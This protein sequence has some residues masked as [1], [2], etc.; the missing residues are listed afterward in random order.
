MPAHLGLGGFLVSSRLPNLTPG[1]FHLF[2]PLLIFSPHHIQIS[3]FTK[4]TIPITLHNT[5]RGVTPQNTALLYDGH[6]NL[7][8]SVGRRD[9][10]V[11]G[12]VPHVFTLQEHVDLAEGRPGHFVPVPALPHQVID[13]LRAV[14]GLGQV[15]LGPVPSVVMP[16]VLYHR[17]IREL[18][19][20]LLSRECQYLPQRDREGPHVALAREFPLQHQD[21]NSYI[22]KTSKI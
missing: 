22:Q 7:L 12:T 13:L 11:L 15:G 8:A 3:S 18:V 9:D 10:I 19:K 1:R 2:C 6:G 20:R 21:I 16:A 14:T 17:L 4:P 5:G